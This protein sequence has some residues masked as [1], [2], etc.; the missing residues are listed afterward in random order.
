MNFNLFYRVAPDKIEYIYRNVQDY[1]ERGGAH[2]DWEHGIDHREGGC[3][4]K[5]ILGETVT[6]AAN[7]GLV[8]H[9]IC[10]IYK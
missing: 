1:K 6:K 10:I 4:A 9:A 3:M 5:A 8:L 2:L 7:C